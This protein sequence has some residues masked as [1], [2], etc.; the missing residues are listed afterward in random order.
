VV[1]VE[2]EVEKVDVE[3]QE[4]EKEDEEVEVEAAMPRVIEEAQNE[5]LTTTI[6]SQGG[7]PRQLRTNPVSSSGERIHRP[8]AG[9][10]P[11][12]TKR[13]TTVQT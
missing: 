10:P 12:T 11:T 9:P 8:A 6:N 2:V 5:M 13:S 4:V 3:E 7:R 1:E